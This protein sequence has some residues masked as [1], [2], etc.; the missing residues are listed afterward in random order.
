MQHFK[1]R[2]INVKPRTAQSS[3]RLLSHHIAN[4]HD[5]T[6]GY[7]IKAEVER[8]VAERPYSLIVSALEWNTAD[9]ILLAIDTVAQ[10][11]K[12]TSNGLIE[13]KIS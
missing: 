5:A 13:F 11:K 1:N 9:G 7:L 8:Q 2:Y 3:H 6:K 12:S 10:R 4:V